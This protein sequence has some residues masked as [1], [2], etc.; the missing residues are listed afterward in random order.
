[1]KL[2]LGLFICLFALLPQLNT[3]ALEK[4]S[5]D[6]LNQ[7]TKVKQNE[8]DKNV[9][10]EDLK[11]LN[12]NMQ[13]AFIGLVSNLCEGDKE[14]YFR[15]KLNLINSEN[16]LSE[17]KKTEKTGKIISEYN[18]YL[19]SHQNILTLNLKKSSLT[20]KQALENAL[21]DFE[22]AGKKY[23]ETAYNFREKQNKK[24][25]E[26]KNIPPNFKNLNNLKFTALSMKNNSM[27]IKNTISKVKVILKNSGI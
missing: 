6:I 18:S 4:N 16:N 2:K 10:P 8:S 21:S 7:E 23:T 1:M 13:E 14:K 17:S 11:S 24:I 19:T 26:N 22:Y 3:D 25:E 27:A 5:L 20:K 12:I 15:E 9:A